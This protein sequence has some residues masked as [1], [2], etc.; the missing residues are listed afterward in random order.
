MSDFTHK[1]EERLSRQHAAER[2][3]DI[4]YALSAG[5]PFEL[6]VDGEQMSVPI[7]DELVVLRTVEST[8]EHVEVQ[9]EL[10][11]STARE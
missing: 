1:Q 3:I 5:P 7:P 9:L 8:G 2:L 11:W 6:R 10:G 4:A